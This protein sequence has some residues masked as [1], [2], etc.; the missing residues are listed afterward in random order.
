M[1]T[2]EEEELEAAEDLAW[3]DKHPVADLATAS[4]AAAGMPRRRRVRGKQ[5]VPKA[6][7]KLRTKATKQRT[8]TFITNLESELEEF[9]EK[10]DDEEKEA[11]GEGEEDAPK[12]ASTSR[13]EKEATKREGGG[14]WTWHFSDP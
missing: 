8:Q 3:L 1:R 12:R 4:F 10:G 14:R 13:F 6:E 9:P 2:P 7:H 5:L 11:E